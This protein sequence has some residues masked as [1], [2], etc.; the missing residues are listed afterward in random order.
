MKYSDIAS[1]LEISEEAVKKRIARATVKIK[2]FMEDN[3]E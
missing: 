2:Q 3:H 1:Q